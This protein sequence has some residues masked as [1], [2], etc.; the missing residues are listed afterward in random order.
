MTIDTRTIAA[1]VLTG[2][3]ASL[4]SGTASAAAAPPPADLRIGFTATGAIQG[5]LANGDTSGING[6]EAP[7]CAV[8][9]KIAQPFDPATHLSTGKRLHSP[10]RVVKKVSASSLRFAKAIAGNE[11]V[12]VTINWY[13]V[14]TGTTLVR[15]VKLTGARVV[16]YQTWQGSCDG[17]VMPDPGLTAESISFTFD[18]AE[19][20]QFD[21]PV[22][23]TL[24]H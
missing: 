21:P 10:I 6:N 11:R 18:K 15:Q 16:E 2:I 13:A 14:G 22:S 4:A 17:S 20:Q 12:D 5:D 23:V 7:A 8:T 24:V 9:A 3:A 1:L 19:W